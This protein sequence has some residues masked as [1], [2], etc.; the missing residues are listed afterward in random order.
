MGGPYPYESGG[1]RELRLRQCW[2]SPCARAAAWRRERRRAACRRT[3]RP[4]SWSAAGPSCNA[5][6]RRCTACA[7]PPDRTATAASGASR[8]SCMSSAAPSSPHL[9][10]TSQPISPSP[11]L[12][13]I[14]KV[15]YQHVNRCNEIRWLRP[16]S[17]L[18]VCPPFAMVQ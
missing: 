2:G 5:R 6:R 11:S 8:S 1:A 17:A 14:A 13:P 12:T 9:L 18:F 7:A 4:R 15:S 16:A 3:C 10:P